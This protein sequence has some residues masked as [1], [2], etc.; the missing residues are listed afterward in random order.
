M[1][2]AKALVNKIKVKSKIISTDE[3]VQQGLQHRAQGRDREALEC[4]ADAISQDRTA[5]PA[6]FQR[7][8][9]YLKY[10]YY[11]RCQRDVE[12]LVKLEP[13]SPVYLTQLGLVQGFLHIPEAGLASHNRALLLPLSDT[14]KSQVVGH[15]GLVQL[16]HSKAI[17]DFSEA[18][19]LDAN[20]Y[21]AYQ[22]RGA[23]YLGLKEYALGL[24]DFEHLIQAQFKVAM[25]HLYCGVA[26]Q[27]QNRHDEAMS[28]FDRALALEP[29]SSQVHNNKGFSLFKQGRLDDALVE[30]RRA[31][32]LDADNSL[33]HYNIG[34]LLRNARRYGEAMPYFAKAFSLKFK[35]IEGLPRTKKEKAAQ[36]VQD[37]VGGA[38]AAL[39]QW[40]ELTIDLGG[41]LIKVAGSAGGIA[42]HLALGPGLAVPTMLLTG[43][44]C[45]IGAS[46]S[47][48]VQVVKANQ[49]QCNRLAERVLMLCDCVMGLDLL[50][51]GTNYELSLQ[52]LEVTLKQS[53]LLME[54]FTSTN[55]VKRFVSAGSYND[56]FARIHQRLNDS[57]QELQLGLNVQS[58]FN[59]KNAR[60]DAE[61][62]RVY[63]KENMGELI[64]LHVEMKNEL[65]RAQLEQDERA[66]I[67]AQQLASMQFEY[68]KVLLPHSQPVLEP[69]FAGLVMI[70]FHALDIEDKIGQG[71]LGTIYRGRYNGEVVAV[72]EITGIEGEDAR[73]QFLREAQIMNHLR[74]QHFA[75]FYGVCSEEDRHYLVTEYLPGGSLDIYLGQ[76]KNLGLVQRHHF[77]KDIVSGLRYLHAAKVYHRDLTSANVL[78]DQRGTAKI[79]DFGLAKVGHH[80]AK[81]VGFGAQHLAS[82]F[83]IYAPERFSL[84][85]QPSSEWDV[86]SLGILMWEILTGQMA[87]AGLTDT[88]I[89][90]RVLKGELE[91]IP[92]YVPAFYQE[93][94]EACWDKLP[95]RRPSVEEINTQLTSFKVPDIEALFNEGLLQEKTYKDY[96]QAVT[97]YQN[98]AA[99]GSFR[100]R[101]NLA[102]LYYDGC[103]VP[104]DE[105]KAHDLLLES[106][107]DGHSR[108]MVNLAILYEEGYAGQ[109]PNLKQA[110]FWLEKAA[111]LGD[112]SAR[113]KLAKMKPVSAVANAGAWSFHKPLK[114]Q[115]K[116]NQPLPEVLEPPRALLGKKTLGGRTE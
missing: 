19:R 100:A 59:E 38:K 113:E 6:Y 11:E 5:A 81:T 31:I 105:Q 103:G 42:L 22:N 78:I 51:S 73:K 29:Q 7:S 55:F 46:M 49:E 8:L 89:T 41:K 115:P 47:R 87:Y 61:A 20:N 98:A 13:D 94:I 52:R 72:K 112:V 69:E 79:A 37:L 4:F 10:G 83:K 56:E 85:A 26:L 34:L 96:D 27:Y 114:H 93:L 101:T 17:A 60:E 64:K 65:N 62:D 106:A 35:E 107:Q 88:E 43:N 102:G 21:L 90:H 67:M 80:V 77:I 16:E 33:A 57:A 110:R 74:S 40:P 95:E 45:E 58:M 104:K 97:C 76:H 2:K 109:K 108:A 91:A 66:K 36:Y 14:V 116:A 12:Q 68:S 32:E 3:L 63:L 71:K 48:Q 70:P 18:I 82:S 92:S 23:L 111:G 24:A 54:E 75:L 28:C 30:F 25:M 44:I 86:Y 99:Y 53:H 39:P 15:R 9:I 1:Q 50:D 84:K